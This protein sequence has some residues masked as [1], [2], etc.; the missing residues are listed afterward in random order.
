LRTG[1]ILQKCL[2]RYAPHRKQERDFL[3]QRALAAKIVPLRTENFPVRET[4][5]FLSA[6]ILIFEQETFVPVERF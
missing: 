5:R 4:E 2:F 6:E 3:K 1:I